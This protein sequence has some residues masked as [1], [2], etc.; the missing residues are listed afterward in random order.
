M[1]GMLS[2]AYILSFGG[3]LAIAGVAC[4]EAGG[5]SGVEVGDADAGVIG[6]GMDTDGDGLSDSLERSIGSNPMLR[7][8]DGDGYTDDQEYE[9]GSDPND[10]ASTPEGQACVNTTATANP[11]SR[12]LDIIVA[13]DASS[14]MQ[15][16]IK[17]IES[18]I[19][20]S[21]SQILDEK[22]ID[23]QVT[24]IAHYGNSNSKTEQVIP[25]V[26]GE[27]QDFFG[28]CIAEPLGGNS[29]EIGSGDADADGVT[30]MVEPAPVAGPK[31]THIDQAID[32]NDALE[33]LM[34]TF[35]RDA[36]KYEEGSKSGQGLAPNGWGARLRD[37]ALKFFVV[38]TDDESDVNAAAFENWLFDPARGG[39][40]GTAN[41]RNYVFHSVVG[42]Q[43]KP[44]DLFWSPGDGIQTAEC[45]SASAVDAVYQQLSID[46]DGLRFSVCNDGDT[47]SYDKM[48]EKLAGNAIAGSQVPCQ[49]ALPA[50]PEGKQYNFDGVILRYTASGGSVEEFH[51]VVTP[52]SCADNRG[53]YASGGSVHLCPDACSTVQADSGAE[54]QLIISCID[55][56]ILR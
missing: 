36:Y 8:S 19:N 4:G 22:G 31:F 39:A 30:D 54:I 32:S 41:S 28:I 56:L 38:F 49:Y 27:L 26:D 42:L 23:Y 45:G 50:A 40:F 15:A 9:F 6:E 12:P 7:D 17:G 48:F 11:E 5:K 2:K 53:Y 18:F 37:G 35:D 43:E 24:L 52:S 55:G 34:Y 3:V 20:D 21:F 29:C 46:S 51:S 1:S 44:G 14:S 16:E 10:S 25:R 33:A 47:T 13:V